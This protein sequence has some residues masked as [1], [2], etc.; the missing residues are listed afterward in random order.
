MRARRSL[1]HSGPEVTPGGSSIRT[2]Q[3]AQSAP[4]FLVLYIIPRR[5]QTSLRGCL[6]GHLGSQKG[7]RK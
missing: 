5:F 2:E 3:F 4:G 7:T 6:H 1:Q